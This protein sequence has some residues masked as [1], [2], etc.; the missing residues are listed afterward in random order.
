MIEKKEE[1]NKEHGKTFIKKSE[2]KNSKKYE[3]THLK[4]LNH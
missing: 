3:I 4:S 2:A 1:S